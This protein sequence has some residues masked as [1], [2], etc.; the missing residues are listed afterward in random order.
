MLWAKKRV[1]FLFREQEGP[2]CLIRE[3]K[4]RACLRQEKTKKIA[5]LAGSKEGGGFPARNQGKKKLLIWDHERMEKPSHCH[6]VKDVDLEALNL[7][8]HSK[9]LSLIAAEGLEHGVCTV[10]TRLQKFE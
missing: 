2:S 10:A 7:A 1:N 8:K 6:E 4:R 5:F 3:Q 9:E